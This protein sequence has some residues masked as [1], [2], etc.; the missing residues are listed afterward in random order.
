MHR[1]RS[2]SRQRL[3]LSADALNIWGPWWILG[4][5][6]TQTKRRRGAQV[7]TNKKSVQEN[8]RLRISL[9]K[10]I[11]TGSEQSPSKKEGLTKQSHTSVE[12]SGHQASSK[13]KHCSH[14]APVLHRS[15]SVTMVINCGFN[16]DPVLL[17]TSVF[18]HCSKRV[19]KHCS[20]LCISSI[21]PDQGL[22]HGA[23]KQTFGL[24]AGLVKTIHQQ[25]LTRL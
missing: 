1:R 22:P 17:Y 18:Q 4:R 14:C 11:Q 16:C 10:Q 3:R 13:Q 8:N 7:Q 5:S 19:E 15:T 6:E 12:M 9:S 21:P 2:L 24:S 25:V 23:Q 20:K